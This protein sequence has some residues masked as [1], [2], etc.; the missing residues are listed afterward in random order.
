M[1]NENVVVIIREKLTS[2]CC[3]AR[4]IG[5]LSSDNCGLCSDCKEWTTFEKEEE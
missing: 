5:E 4:S 2:S 1:I 3:D